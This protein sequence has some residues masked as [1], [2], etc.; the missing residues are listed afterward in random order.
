MAE[1]TSA[2]TGLVKKGYSPMEQYAAESTAQGP[3]SDV[4]SFG[5]TLYRCATGREPQEATMRVL[6]DVAVPATAFAG[7]KILK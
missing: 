3:W 1:L 7:Q 4:Y 2:L 5:A 6:K